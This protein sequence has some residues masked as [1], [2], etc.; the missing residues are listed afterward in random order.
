MSPES[1]LSVG[2]E[3]T[4]ERLWIEAVFPIRNDNDQLNQPDPLSWWFG[5]EIQNVRD[6]PG[7]AVVKNLP[8][9]A[10]EVGLIPGR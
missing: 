6:F 10:G 7:G 9:D 4:N 1:N 3:V 2:W 5:L 8:S